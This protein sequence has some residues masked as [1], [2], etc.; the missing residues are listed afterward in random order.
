MDILVEKVRVLEGR[1]PNPSFVLI[2]SQ[3]VKTA[4]A[5]DERGIDGGK[6]K[7]RDANDT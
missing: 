1:E 7:L 5:A 6:K 4:G 3:S 2:D